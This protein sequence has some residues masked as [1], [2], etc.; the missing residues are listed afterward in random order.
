MAR[1]AL[2]INSQLNRTD[3]MPWGEH[4]SMLQQML[5][6]MLPAGHRCPTYHPHARKLAA[7][8]P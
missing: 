2:K 4:P 1:E 5:F 3:S 7:G 6:F 8:K